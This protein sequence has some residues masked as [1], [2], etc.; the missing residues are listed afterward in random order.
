VCVCVCVC[1]CDHVQLLICL[2][3]SCEIYNSVAVSFCQCTECCLSRGE[4]CHRAIDPTPQLSIHCISSFPDT[5]LTTCDTCFK[6]FSVQLGCHDAPRWPQV[7]VNGKEMPNE[8]CCFEKHVV[9]AS[10]SPSA[11]KAHG[12]CTWEAQWT[13]TRLHINVN[14]QDVLNMKLWL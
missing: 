6:Y 4:Q 5:W 8:L 7:R 11:G 12:R 14:I 1:V 10:L 9:C 2:N 3:V 13:E